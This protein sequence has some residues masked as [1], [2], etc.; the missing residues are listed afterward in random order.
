M[1]CLHLSLKR[2]GSVDCDP[3]HPISMEPSQQLPG[4]NN[5]LT[6]RLQPL[7][8]RSAASGDSF[9]GSPRLTSTSARFVQDAPTW[10]EAP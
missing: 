2:N 8:N 10:P 5:R 9:D 7:A 1:F 4:I 3:A 6:Q